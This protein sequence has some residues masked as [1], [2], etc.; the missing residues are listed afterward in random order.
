VDS[1]LSD[2]SQFDMN[3]YLAILIL[4]CIANLL[5][6]KAASD[7][8]PQPDSLK[9]KRYT[10]ET[11]RVIGEIPSETIGAITVKQ[12][13]ATIQPIP[14]N[15][16][17]S[18]EDV[19]GVSVT[20]GTKDE[21]NLRIRGFRKNEVKILVDGRPLNAGYFGSVDLQN[22]PVS[23]IKSIQILKGPISSM[24][25]SNTMGG[26]VN[27][28]TKEPSDKKWA[29]LGM[30]FKR[31]NTNHLELSTSHSFT[32]WNYWVY[33]ARDNTDGFMLPDDFVPAA[34]ENGAM[35]NHLQKTQYNFQ[36]KTNFTL[37]DL[38]TIGF[39]GGYTYIDR[40]KIP[41]S[42]YTAGEDYRE[43]KDWQRYQSTVM[44]DDILSETTTLKTMLWLDGGQDTYQTFTYR[45]YI[46]KTNSTIKYSTLGFNPLLE[47]QWGDKAKLKSGYRGEIVH[48]TRKDNGDYPDW[49]AHNIWLNNLF[50]QME[51]QAAH[52]LSLTGGCGLA[53]FK[54]DERDRSALF[55]EP[56][57]GAYYGFKDGSHVSLA[58]GLNSSYPTMQQLYS[59]D[60]GNPDL[61][62]QSSAKFELAGQKPFALSF[63]SGSVGTEIYYNA[64]THLIDEVDGKYRNIDKVQTYGT[65]VN[66]IL[67]PL[68]YWE[69][70]ASYAWLSQIQADEYKL[71]ESPH[72]SAE[73][74]SI[75]HLPAGISVAWTSVYKDYR[76]SQDDGFDYRVLHPYWL[77]SINLRAGWQC[78]T[79]NLGVENLTDTY[80]EEEYGFPAAG[81]NFNLGLEA[82]I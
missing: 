64:V 55:I 42:I 58:A 70:D 33:G 17:E 77:H 38:H 7:N 65:E 71:T 30:Q 29:H 34:S 16:K 28:I 37:F 57:F 54:N 11:V 51:Y 47:Y 14:V 67:Q 36:A 61:E 62:P 53:A 15:I 18:L 45:D 25:G 43:Y 41:Q 39:T 79:F 13:D 19:S 49:T 4:L 21:S 23:D 8:K 44:S 72:N 66:L 31:N 10:L 69:L 27:L 24:Y 48:S 32:D 63:L 40:K 73:L 76:L 82:E 9:L 52:S 59:A 26:V 56:T 81:I 1:L 78:F 46:L 3:R 68:K 80:Y 22:L 50:T 6:A 60:K 12:L 5:T 35:R 2:N 75:F 74:S 20:V